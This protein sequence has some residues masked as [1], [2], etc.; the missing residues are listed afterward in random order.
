MPSKESKWL[1][2]LSGPE[3]RQEMLE[4]FKMAIRI[5][6]FTQASAKLLAQ[7]IYL[8]L[9]LKEKDLLS[10]WMAAQKERVMIRD[11][12]K[13]V[14]RENQ[15]LLDAFRAGKLSSHM[16]EEVGQHLQARTLVEKREKEAGRP[17]AK[18][19]RPA[20]P[21]RV[22]SEA[23]KQETLKEKIKRYI[24]GQVFESSSVNFLAYLY[25]DL[26]DS[27]R[28]ALQKELL[29]HQDARKMMQRLEDLEHA[30]KMLE[31]RASKPPPPTKPKKPKP[32]RPR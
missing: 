25:K 6:K 17:K 1:E 3:K 21:E 9:T 13:E 7:N 20:K 11:R 2:R 28:Q 15:A 4:S 19:A 10:D 5:P 8:G 12:L 30:T 22:E 14:L 31:A 16:R 18:T 26:S 27:H 24:T 29:D 32:R 23:E